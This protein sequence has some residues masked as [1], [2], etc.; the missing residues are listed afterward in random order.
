VKSD[1]RYIRDPKIAL[2]RQLNSTPEEKG[3][4]KLLYVGRRDKLV[5]EIRSTL[6]FFSFIGNEIDV[7]QTTTL[8]EAKNLG[9]TMEGLIFILVDVDVHLNGSFDA[10]NLIFQNKKGEHPVSVT[11]TEKLLKASPIDDLFKREEKQQKEEVVVMERLKDIVRM[12]LLTNEIDLKLNL[13]AGLGIPNEIPDD[14]P[15]TTGK[16]VN[17]TRD[18]LYTILAHELKEPVGNIKVML[19]FLTREK[20]LLDQKT[21]NDLLH[22]VRQSVDSINEML[23]D[24]LFWTRM[25]KHHIHYNPRKVSVEQIIRENSTLLKSTAANKN[26]IIET[27]LSGNLSVYADE[28]MITTVVR[29]LLYNA[30][31]FTGKFGKVEISAQE[32]SGF[33]EVS[34]SDNGIGM[35]EKDLEKIFKSDVYFKTRGTALETGTGVGLVLCKDFIEKNGGIISVQS[36]PKKGTTF[37]FTLPVWENVSV[38]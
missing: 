5:A 27:Q 38:N 18:K 23:D 25:N 3:K 36:K 37:R 2:Y 34:I 28:Y 16:S 29:N 24:F 26:I 30:I 19:D 4:F 10:F 8:E 21:Y 17:I 1:P 14:N 6:R 7:L 22:N 9:E 15:A 31:K 35:T 33:V 12:I 20:E 32:K 11:T 13:S